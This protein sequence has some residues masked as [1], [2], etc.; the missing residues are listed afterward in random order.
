MRNQ[1]RLIVPAPDLKDLIDEI[2]KFKPEFE[3][4]MGLGFGS[5]RRECI[6]QVEWM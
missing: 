3:A 2:W 4:K 1:R 6:L 5:L